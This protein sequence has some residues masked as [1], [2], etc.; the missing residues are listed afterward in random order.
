MLPFI[1][2]AALGATAVVAVNNNEKIKDKIVGG[3]NTLKDSITEN[4]S[5]AKEKLCETKASVKKTIH[6]VTAEDKSQEEEK[7]IEVKDA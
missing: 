6:D 2:G 7:Q 5:K 1:I 4:T 3:A